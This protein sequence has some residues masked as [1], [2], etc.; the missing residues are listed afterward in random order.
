VPLYD[1]VPELGR[2][3]AAFAHLESRLAAVT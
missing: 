1:D 2:A 3:L